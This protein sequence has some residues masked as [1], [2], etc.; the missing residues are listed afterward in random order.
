MTTII[1]GQVIIKAPDATMHCRKL[2]LQRQ[3]TACI[4]IAKVT[5]VVGNIPITCSVLE[6]SV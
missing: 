5:E 3:H 2:K 6:I 4:L 1:V